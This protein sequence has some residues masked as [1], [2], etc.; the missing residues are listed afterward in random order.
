MSFVSW[1]SKIS[2]FQTYQL[3]NQHE[4]DD[5]PRYGNNHILRQCF[6]HVENAGVPCAGRCADLPR[7]RT[8]LVID[9]GKHGFEIGQH[10]PLQHFLY[11]ISDFVNDSSHE[12]L[13]LMRTGWR[14]EGSPS[15]PQ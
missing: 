8:Y 3:I 13:S 7:N 2:F 1:L 5:H 12:G 11:E 6:Y 4:A 9:I 15:A 10:P 14:A